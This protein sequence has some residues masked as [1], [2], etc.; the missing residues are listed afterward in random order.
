MAICLNATTRMARLRLTFFLLV[1]VQAVHSIE[2]YRGRLYEVF[3]P[4]R[5][6]SGL[7]SPDLARGFVI[8]NVALVSFGLWCFWWPLRHQWP[9]AA[10][11]AWIWVGIELVNGVG[12]PLWSLSMLRYTPGVATAPLL[13]LLAVYLAW[14]VRAVNAAR[15]RTQLP[16]ISPKE[17]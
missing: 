10:L 6:M 3:P 16:G 9:S 17:S 1:V 11:F 13:L 5:L 14:Q 15:K 4:A 8:F 2:E 7:I 12:H